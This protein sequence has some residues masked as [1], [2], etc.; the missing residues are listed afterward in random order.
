MHSVMFMIVMKISH[1]DALGY[2]NWFSSSLW[3]WEEGVICS[4]SVLTILL[5]SHHGFS[6]LK[7][8]LIR[9][10]ILSLITSCK[11]FLVKFVIDWTST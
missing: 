7:N 4:D 1:I 10:W 8:T 2:L 5:I 6:V 9:Y 3:D 11:T